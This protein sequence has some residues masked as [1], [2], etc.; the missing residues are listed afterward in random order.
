[1][2][3]DIYSKSTLC[4]AG[5]KACAVRPQRLVAAAACD[6]FSLWTD[7]GGILGKKIGV[8]ASG[9][10]EVSRTAVEILEAGGNAFDAALGALCT[11]AIA[12]PLLVSLGGGGFML[13]LPDGQ[14]PRVYDF[15]CQ[16]PSRR[17]PTA[18]LDF[19]PIMANFGTAAQEFHIGMGSIAVPGIIAGIFE[20]HRELGRMPLQD[21]MTPAI[22]LARGGVRVDEFHHYIIRILRPIMQATPASFRLFES[23]AHPG[24]LIRVGELLCNPQAADSLEALT[25]E[26]QA[27]FYRGEWA[28]QFA[29]DCLERGGHITRED[30]ASYQV[31][32]RE[33]VVFRYRG[34]RCAI[35]PPPSPG[36]CLIAFALGVISDWDSSKESWGSVGHAMNLL[37]GMRAASVARHHYKLESGLERE[38]MERLLGE[39]TVR[40]WQQGLELNSLFSRGTTHISV[41]DRAGNIASLTAS[42][43]EGCA[44]VLPGTGIMLNNMLGEEDLNFGGFH[45][46][47]E[48]V[49]LASMMSPAV[50]EL[51]D[52]T[53]IALGTGG[54]NRIRSAITQVLVNLLDFGMSLEQ[55]VTASRMHLE[56]DM[57]SI[58]AGFP[59]DAVTALTSAVPQHHLWPESNLFFG[60]VHTVSIKHGGIFDGAGD[61]RRG[62]VVAFARS[63]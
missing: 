40:E 5:G 19:Y 27:L 30:L 14:K 28:A 54:S 3:T 62:G 47:K 45:R 36:G 60:G 11:A 51:A 21:I 43:G 15:F 2:G 32:R 25:R 41:A 61:P 12:E 35:N 20:A 29:R 31:E 22:E 10:A 1:M 18:E 55:A 16:T 7:R 49:R 39:E 46:W 48:N 9:S 59:E 23:P 42:N 6:I 13:A 53:R 56:G 44:Y 24:R 8:A 58:E 26:G 57:L 17:R 50:A 63:G 4:N 37:R 38:K 33:P 34:T 52:G